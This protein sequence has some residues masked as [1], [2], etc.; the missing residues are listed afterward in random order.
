MPSW[1][2]GVIDVH[3]PFQFAEP[4]CWAPLPSALSFPYQTL[5]PVAR[6]AKNALRALVRERTTCV[7]PGSHVPVHAVE[8]VT[9][10][11]LPVSSIVFAAPVELL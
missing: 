2:N 6:Y 1:R 7:Q 11:P 8:T 5:P 4:W 9:L 3:N 10:E